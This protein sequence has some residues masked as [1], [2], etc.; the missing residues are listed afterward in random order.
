MLMT[1]MTQLIRLLYVIIMRFKL[2]LLRGEQEVCNLATPRTKIVFQS[3]DRPS[4]KFNWDVCPDSGATR[5]LISHQIWE[6]Y[7][8]FGLKPT[9]SRMIT[10]NGQEMACS[11]QISLQI[12]SPQAP[13]NIVYV[14]A[15]VSPDMKKDIL[16]SW[17]DMISLNIL[18]KNF[19]NVIPSDERSYAAVLKSNRKSIKT[20]KLS[21]S[22][23][24][25]PEK[26]A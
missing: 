9:S 12:Y 2:R 15:L 5:T 7:I 19:P 16:L 8:N 11:G 4:L 22:K 18:H 1:M 21:P 26:S 25:D 20:R 6:K 23:S 10:A 24:I 14:N 13:N 3:Y 17:Q